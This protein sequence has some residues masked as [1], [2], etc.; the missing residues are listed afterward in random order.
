MDAGAILPPAGSAGML[1]QTIETA[2]E[3]SKP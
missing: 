1:Q 2:V 3:T